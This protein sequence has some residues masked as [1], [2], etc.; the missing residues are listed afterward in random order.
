MNRPSWDQYFMDMAKLVAARATCPVRQVGA[1]FVD[2]NNSVLSIGYNGAA[3][4]TK[5]CGDACKNRKHGE[6]TDECRAVHSETNAILNAARNGIKLEGSKVYVTL[7]PCARCANNLIQV[8]V[9]E[10]IYGSNSAYPEVVEELKNSKVIIK[11]LK[12]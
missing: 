10:V 9:T 11:K 8:G 7:S 12:A 6:K 3:R 5:H 4:G 1:V 2:K